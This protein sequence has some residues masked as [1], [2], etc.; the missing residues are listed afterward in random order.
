MN[1]FKRFVR[2]YGWER[3]LEPK[4]IAESEPE[5]FSWVVAPREPGTHPSYRANTYI[6][7]PRSDPDIGLVSSPFY[8]E[9]RQDWLRRY[10]RVSSEARARA[11]MVERAPDD[12]L[13][14]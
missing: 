10:P 6:K 14:I 11:W 13:F 8:E 3:Y 2:W 1:W 9:S 12:C 5:F 7:V 4:Q